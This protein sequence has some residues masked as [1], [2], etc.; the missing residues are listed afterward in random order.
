MLAARSFRQMT[1]FESPFAMSLGRG[2]ADDLEYLEHHTYHW[3]GWKRHHWP[4]NIVR[5]GVRLYGFDLRH[6]ALR[7]LLEVTRG[8]TFLYKSKR[9]FASKVEHL[10]GWKPSQDDPHWATIPSLDRG[11]EK[12]E[13]TGLALRWRVIKP[14]R[15]PISGR[16]PRLGW[17]KLD[18][19][20]RTTGDIDPLQEFEE[21]G[22]RPVTTCGQS[23]IQFSVRV[24]KISGAFGSVGSGALRAGW[25]LRNATDCLE[26]ISSKCTTRYL[27]RFYQVVPC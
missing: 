2:E 21:G 14:V 3:T 12:R 24:R 7:V 27:G 10:T 18:A 5:P 6:R 8:G 17:M 25:C 26:P 9:E 20:A 11:G 16:F 4:A 15:I 19:T 23:G 22:L 1:S 13:N